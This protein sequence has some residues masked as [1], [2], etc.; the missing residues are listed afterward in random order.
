LADRG[1]GVLATLKRVRPN[2]NTHEAALA[3]AFTEIISG[4]APEERGNGLKFVK[5][6]ITEN[7]MGLVFQSG[8]TEVI[9]HKDDNGLH[10]NSSQNII[11][12]CLAFITF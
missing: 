8:D 2:L 12:G 6:V 3:T 4:R 5:K 9:L 11:R 10:M 1:I 7:P